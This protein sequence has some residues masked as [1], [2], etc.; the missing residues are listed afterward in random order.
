MT[1]QGFWLGAA[2]L[3]SLMGGTAA[4]A[5]P[6]EYARICDAYGVGFIYIPGTEKCLNVSTGEIRQET[7]DGTVTSESELSGRVS[8]LEERMGDWGEVYDNIAISRALLSPDMMAGEQFAL[9]L[10]WGTAE[11][12]HAF[13]VTG[14]VTFTE[15]FLDGGRGRITGYGGVAFGGKSVGGNAGLQ[16]SW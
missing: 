14:A 9:R 3:G 11:S 12:S 15:G 8:S 6:V 4:S 13:G 1:K 16:F 7:V 2:V 10:N 5:A